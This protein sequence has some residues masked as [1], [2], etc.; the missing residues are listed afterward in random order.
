MKKKKKLLSAVCLIVS[1]SI[2]FSGCTGGQQTKT[3]AIRGS[4]TVLPLAQSLSEKYMQKETSID[5]SVSGG[6]SGVGIAS[7]IGGECDI[8]DASRDIKDKEKIKLEE[9]G[10]K[11]EPVPI[12]I[13]AMAIVVNKNNPLTKL[14]VKQVKDIYSGE[15]KNWKELG[16]QDLEIV[17][18]ERESSSGTFEVFKKL[19]MEGTDV[20]ATS[21]SKP[22]NGAIVSAIEQNPQAIGYVGLAYVDAEKVKPLDISKDGTNYYTPTEENALSKNYA[23]W[24]YL[25]MITKEDA[26]EH[27]K[28]FI[29]FVKSEEG[30]AIVKSIGYIAPQA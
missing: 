28:S 15:I 6:G 22:S 25:Y 13:D 11:Y 24:R 27:V 14:T 19:I 3:I 20:V 2:F 16:G 4:D 12:A 21:L 26:P 17:L 23:L 5:I 1:L 10:I 9:K 8:A 29:N 18:Y 30:K 7:F